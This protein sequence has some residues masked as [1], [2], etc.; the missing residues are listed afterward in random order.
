MPSL[1]TLAAISA[2][3]QLG[4][5]DWQPFNHPG[6]VNQV[7]LTES[8]VLRIPRTEDFAIEDTLTEHH[9][10]PQIQRHTQTPALIAFDF[11]RDLLS[12]PFSIFSR[13][14]AEPI[15]R[16][17]AV[18]YQK[19]AVA[20]AQVHKLDIPRHPLADWHPKPNLTYYQEIINQFIDPNRDWIQS[21]FNRLAPLNDLPFIETFIHGDLH[22]HNLLI[23]ANQN[24]WLIDWG[25]GGHGDPAIDFAVLPTGHFL[26]TLTAYQS[27]SNSDQSLTARVVLHQFLHHLRMAN[28]ARMQNHA[29]P[30]HPLRDLFNLVQSHASLKSFQPTN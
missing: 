21:W 30:I 4:E 12:V 3:H 29:D 15:H 10:L 28:S 8:F 17:Q 9:L 16:A 24:P 14:Q 2:K 27:I 6:I 5:S 25:D 18:N 26:P 11:D 13:I 20:I 7:F 1:S 19:I 22:E 23:D